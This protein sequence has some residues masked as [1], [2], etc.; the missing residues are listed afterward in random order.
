MA[1][2]KPPGWP[3]LR[4]KKGVPPK[5]NVDI[6]SGI[7]LIHK[8]NPKF[9]SMLLKILVKIAEA[10]GFSTNSV[11]NVPKPWDPGNRKS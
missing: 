3:S 6:T 10:T 11:S 2:K 7:P 5:K 9:W 1:P 4:R 8:W